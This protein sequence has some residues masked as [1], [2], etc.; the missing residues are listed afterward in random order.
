MDKDADY[1]ASKIMGLR[2]FEDNEGK[3]NLSL[4][5]IN[6]MDAEWYHS[7]LSSET[8]VRVKGRHLRVRQVW[9]E[10]KLC[11][12]TWLKSVNKAILLSAKGFSGKACWLTWSMTDP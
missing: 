2:I 10:Q 12:N 6:G 3:M 5:D 1:V 4:A 11:M 8:A 7:S 9:K